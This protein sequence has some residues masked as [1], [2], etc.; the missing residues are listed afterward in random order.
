[1]DTTVVDVLPENAYLGDESNLVLLM[2]DI[3]HTADYFNLEKFM[4]ALKNPPELLKVRYFFY[5]G[6]YS[7]IL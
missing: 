5:K 7:L 1:M 2:F 4:L 6:K 3:S